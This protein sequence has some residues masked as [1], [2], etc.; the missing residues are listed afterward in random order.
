M[1]S[2]KHVIFCFENCE[3]FKID[4]KHFGIFQMSDMS[5]SICRIACNMIAKQNCISFVAMEIFS[6]GNQDYNPFGISNLTKKIFDRITESDDI[7]SFTIHY[8]DDSIKSTI[9]YRG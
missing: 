7:T 2:V 1:K 9:T 5:T 8:D 6:E 4:A 3:D